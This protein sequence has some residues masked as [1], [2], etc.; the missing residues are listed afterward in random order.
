MSTR[1]RFLRSSLCASALAALGLQAAGTARFDDTAFRT[2]HNATYAGEP[3]D[4]YAPAYRYG[5][6]AAS[7]PRYKGRAWSEV[8]ND[9]RT[10]YTRRN[11]NS[12]WE[13]MKA[14]VRYGWDKVTG[15]A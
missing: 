6:D 12:A 4:Q 13:R 7:D 15:K 11:P 5:Y 8:E 9:L 10:D 3:Y 1:R 14:A 2:Y